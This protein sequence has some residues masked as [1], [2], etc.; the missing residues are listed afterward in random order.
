MERRSAERGA[1]AAQ[2]LAAGDR[3]HGR[4]EPSPRVRG[5]PTRK[6]G[7]CRRGRRASSRRTANRLDIIQCSQRAAINWQSFSIGRTGHV[8]FQQPSAS[9]ATLNRVVGADPSA[10]IGRL[11]ANGQVFLINPNGVLFGQGAKID[12]GSLVTSTA[13]ISN[14]NFMAGSPQVRR[15]DETAPRPSSTAARSRRRRA[16]WWRS[17]PR[18]WRT[19]A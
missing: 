1:C 8:N 18:G 13:N 15:G 2:A 12:V 10:I 9:A 7:W 5:A 19:R 4:A 6:A 16:G 11:T 3:G 14:E 17:S